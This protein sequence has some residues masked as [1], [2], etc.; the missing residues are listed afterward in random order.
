MTEIRGRPLLRTSMN[1]ELTINVNELPG[2]TKSLFRVIATDGVNT[3]IDD[4][5]NTFNIVPSRSTH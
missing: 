4:S 3:A 1:R 2:S 5:D